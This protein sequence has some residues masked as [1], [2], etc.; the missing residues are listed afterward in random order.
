MPNCTFK[1]SKLRSKKARQ[2][3]TKHIHLRHPIESSKADSAQEVVTNDVGKEVDQ[4][5]YTWFM[6]VMVDSR[7]TFSLK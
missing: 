7:L 4:K 1:T 6:M 2:R 5:P 3:L